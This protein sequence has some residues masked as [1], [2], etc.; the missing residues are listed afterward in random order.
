TVPRLRWRGVPLGALLERA[1]TL[2]RARFVAI[3]AGEFVAV[4]PLNTVGA[5]QPLLA[6]AL[7]GAPLPREHGGP[8]RL[9]AGD[10]LCY[11]SVKWVDRLVVSDVPPVESARDLAERRV[12]RGAGAE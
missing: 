9:V 7:N 2:P 5:T 4:L 11:R 6:W 12:A 3:G 8:L 10:L 1:G